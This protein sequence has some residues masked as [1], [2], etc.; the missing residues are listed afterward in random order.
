MIRQKDS[1]VSSSDNFRI[2][3]KGGLISKS[4]QNPGSQPNSNDLVQRDVSA[5]AAEVTGAF[6]TQIELERQRDSDNSLNPGSLTQSKN[7]DAWD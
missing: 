1:Q 6:G 7:A 5:G 3:S 4:A 2:D